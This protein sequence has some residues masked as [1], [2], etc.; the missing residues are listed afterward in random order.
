M[1]LYKTGERGSRPFKALVWRRILH[2]ELCRSL[3]YSIHPFKVTGVVK[4]AGSMRILINVNLVTTREKS[5]MCP[6]I[7]NAVCC[8]GNYK[9]EI[10]DVPF[11]LNRLISEL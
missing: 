9:R 6:F 8:F 10:N 1:E 7:G 2:S 4:Y 11:S 3:L 5:M